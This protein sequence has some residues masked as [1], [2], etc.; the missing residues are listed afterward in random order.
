M[1]FD[2]TAPAKSSVEPAKFVEG[3]EEL[4]EVEDEDPQDPWTRPPEPPA[5]FKD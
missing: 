3:L 4:E 5:S 1:S 2:P